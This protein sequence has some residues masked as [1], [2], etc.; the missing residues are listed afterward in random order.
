[1]LSGV[2]RWLGVN[3]EIEYWAIIHDGEEISA[4]ATENAA[5]CLVCCTDF[6]KIG[7]VKVEHRKIE[8]FNSANDALNSL[9]KKRGEKILKDMSYDDRQ[10]VLKYC[11]Q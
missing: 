11:E 10:A 9:R 3:K 6:D 4:C 2:Q 8:I 7:K 1:M 5:T